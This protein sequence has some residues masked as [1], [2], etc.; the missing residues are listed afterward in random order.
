MVCVHGLRP[1]DPKA[2]TAAERGGD[3]ARYATGLVSGTTL[4][5]DVTGGLG[6]ALLL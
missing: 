3:I 2:S 5:V 4:A 6:I 1:T